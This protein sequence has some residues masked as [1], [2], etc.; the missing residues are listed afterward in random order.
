MHDFMNRLLDWAS[1]FFAHRPGLL[2]LVAIGLIVLNFLL[3]IFPGPGNWL[4]DSNLVLH[5]GLVLGLLGIL[6]FRPLE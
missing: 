5:V 2:P 6:L 1:D 3:Q 4:A